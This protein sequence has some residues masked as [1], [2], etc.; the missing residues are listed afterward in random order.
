LSRGHRPDSAG[1]L[2]RPRLP[3][4][5]APRGAVKD[6]LAVHRF[7]DKLL[8]AELARREERRIRTSLLLSSLPPGQT[9]CKFDWTLATCAWI[10]VQTKAPG[11]AGG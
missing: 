8:A 6:N 9:L 1:E 4:R 2:G 11:S 7:L 10:P 5:G 3:A